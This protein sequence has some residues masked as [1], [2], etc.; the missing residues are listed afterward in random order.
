MPLL[1]CIQC[2]LEALAAGVSFPA[3]SDET[4]EQHMARVHPGGVT[5]EHR[6]NVEQRAAERLRKDGTC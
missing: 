1:H 4:P 6:A 3:P 5:R 2:V